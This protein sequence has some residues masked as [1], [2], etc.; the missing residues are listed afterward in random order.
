MRGLNYRACAGGVAPRIDLYENS[1]VVELSR[2]GGTWT[3][4]TTKGSVTAP[5]VILGVNGLVEAFGQFRGRLMHVFTYASMTAPFTGKAGRDRW[6]LLPADPMGA[7]VRKITGPG[8]SRI[9]IRTRYTY[10]PSAEVSERRVAAMAACHRRSL[11]ARFPDLADLGFEYSW[12]GRL[13]LSLNHVPAFGEVEE[14]LYSACC[15]NGLGTVK[16]TLAGMMAAD[17]ATVTRSGALDDYQDQPKPRRLPP[18]PIARLGASAV[19]RWQEVRAGR[20][21]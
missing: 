12:A 14:G 2:A 13:C 15:C 17:L 20:E 6:G 21:G 18:E 5:K 19:I 9:A 7:T 1:A 3:A 16:S 11:D 10:D 8:G 4:R